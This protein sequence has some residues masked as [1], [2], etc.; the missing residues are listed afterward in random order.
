MRSSVTVHRAPRVPVF[1]AIAAALGLAC[2]LSTFAVRVIGQAPAGASLTLFTRNAQR[3]IPLAIVGDQ[4][5]IG[6]DELASTFQLSVREEA[7]AVTVSYKGKTV[8]LN[9][10]QTIASVAGRMISLPARPVR[11]GNRLLVP[12]DFISRAIAPIYD[13]KI[14]LRRPSHLLLVGDVRVPRVSISSEPFNSG[15]RMII[16]ATP[17]A[18]NSITRD[19]ERL[20][21]KF[22]ADAIDV[23]IPTIQPQPV[24][25]AIRRLDANGIAIELGPRF[26]SYRS[27][28]QA[29]DSATRLTLELLPVP[30]EPGGPAGTPGATGL[31]GSP[32]S[33][34]P[35]GTGNAP[36][37]TG[38]APPVDLPTFGQPSTPIRTVAIDPGHGGA[39]EG[40]KGPGGLT[41]KA[42]TLS[43]A[44]RAKSALEARL[45]IR[46][47]L[48]RDDDADVP[49]DGRTAVANNNKAD[50][51]I[52]LHANASF[53]PTASGASVLVAQ[54]PDEGLVKQ[55][56]EPHRVPVFGGG[57]RDIELVPW[58]QA[59]IRYLEQ[60]DVFAKTLHAQFEARGIPLDLRPTDRAPLRVLA[61]ANMP[62]VLVELGYVSNPEQEG[63]LGGGDFQG[64][65]AQA[66][67]DAVA[68]FRDY[69]ART[70]EAER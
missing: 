21:V 9:P 60:S 66:I 26:S 24:L 54:F 19:G 58:N 20:L 47:L 33:P 6:L 40:A 67:V 49:F 45:G 27:S 30:P 38:A 62:A 3:P 13:Q 63:K 70:P 37:T 14:E 51:F 22:D 52:S 17:Q 50:L 41:E 15:L 35:N 44:R 43:V 68:G 12:V 11:S 46:V 32:G 23:V 18:S 5:M 28:S 25:Q 36:T 10:E 1:V 59:Q 39:D 34:S 48:T 2:V 4:E 61:S 56:L 7:G 42:L 29:V 65:A 53:R 8:V 31:P 57:L 69:L 64:T 55:T 16:D